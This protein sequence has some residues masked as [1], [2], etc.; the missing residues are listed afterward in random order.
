MLDFENACPHVAVP[1]EA[2][3]ARWAALAA[4][5]AHGGNTTRP[6]TLGIRIVDEQESAQ[7]NR[8][9]RGKDYATNVLSFS[10]EL[11]DF[12]L[13]A[14]EEYPLGDLA[15]CAPVVLREAAQQ[16]KPA[17]DHWA[18]MVIHGVLHLLGHDHED[19][20][21]AETMEAL[22]RILLKDLGIADP[23]QEKP[24]DHE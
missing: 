3:F 8:D 16:G 9:Y 15:I 20:A 5:K 18:H 2:D 7:L 14:L 12:M 17:A 13:N 23:Y 1:A 24:L 21:A 6:V 11:P 22:E 4:A 19:D 10:H